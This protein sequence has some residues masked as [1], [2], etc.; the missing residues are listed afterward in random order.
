MID[1]FFCDS[2]SL[3]IIGL[4]HDP[5]DISYKVYDLLKDEFD[6]LYPINPRMT[7]LITGERCYK[8]LQEIPR[9]DT[10]IFFTDPCTSKEMLPECKKKGIDY[11]W[12]QKGSANEAVM[13]EAERLGFVVKHS[14]IMRLSNFIF[15]FNS[16]SL[17]RW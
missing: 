11:V 10:A 7:R 17:F 15:S 2:D 4:S 8:S 14:R 12:F 9:V 3:A 1:P 16:F 6:G 5:Y 13:G